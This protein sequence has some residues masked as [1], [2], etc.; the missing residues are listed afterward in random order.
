HY[1]GIGIRMVYIMLI[2]KNL[3]VRAGGKE[4]LHRINFNFEKGKIYALM[5]PNGSGKTSLALTIMGNPNYKATEESEIIFNKKE[6]KNLKP[7]ARAKKGLFLSFQ[8]SPSFEG[9]NLYQMFYSLLSGKVNILKTKSKIDKIAEKLKIKKELLKRSINND[10]SGGEKKKIE[11]LQALLLKPRLVIFD[12]V[13]S[14]VDIDALKTLSHNLLKLKNNHN[15]F[16]FVSH[17]LAFFN[18]VKPE[19]VLIMKEGRIIE[20]GDYK[21]LSKIEKKGYHE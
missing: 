14:G 3:T 4:I 20:T 11:V 17:H 15:T 18:F 8:N 16:I 1:I 7:E 13:D 2:I 6:I 12:E 21:L 9:V 5:G 19:K 10:F